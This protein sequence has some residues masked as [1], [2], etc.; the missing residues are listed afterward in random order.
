M[1]QTKLEGERR[2]KVNNYPG[3]LPG[4]QAQTL[5]QGA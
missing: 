2:E 3:V 4:R 5:V 1:C